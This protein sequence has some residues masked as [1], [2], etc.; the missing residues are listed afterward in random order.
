MR[1]L[2]RRLLSTSDATVANVPPN[3]TWDVWTIVACN[4]HTSAVTFRLHH[5]RPVLSETSGASNAIFYDSRVAANETVEWTGCG[6]PLIS[7]GTGETLN[8]LESSG[9]K[10][11]VSI[12]GESRQS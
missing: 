4:S 6:G 2:A 5:L 10:I 3:E 12:Y 1:L 9:S 7:V 11:C 8:G